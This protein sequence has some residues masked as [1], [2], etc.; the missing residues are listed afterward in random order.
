LEGNRVFA[1][2]RLQPLLADLQGQELDLAGLRA[3][4]QRITDYYQKQGYVLARAFLPPQDIE[5]GLVR[6]AV[7]E[8]RYGR[9]EVQNRS[10]ALDQ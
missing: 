6:I 7:V 4:A 9:I 8:G 5:N 3:A 10:R 1:T 2:E